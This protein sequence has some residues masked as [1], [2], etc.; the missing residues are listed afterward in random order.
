MRMRD[1]YSGHLRLGVW[2]A[3]AVAALIPLALW[4][5]RATHGALAAAAL[6]AQRRAEVQ[7][8]AGVAR[9]YP[10]FQPSFRTLRR[11]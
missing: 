5:V 11:A 9:R 4:L 2:L 10:A 6:L 8:L 7:R 1:V 3:L